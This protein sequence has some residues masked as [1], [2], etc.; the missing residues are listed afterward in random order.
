MFVE[1]G[2]DVF[3]IDTVGRRS[4]SELGLVQ[5]TVEAPLGL[6]QLRAPLELLLE[7]GASGCYLLRQRITKECRLAQSLLQLR[8]HRRVLLRSGAR[9]RFRLAQQR[10]AIINQLS[11]NLD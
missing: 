10:P 3:E 6:V 11:T 5:P 7:V 9:Q 1:F 8:R 2:A 4:Q